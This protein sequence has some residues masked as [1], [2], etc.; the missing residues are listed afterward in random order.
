L[1]GSLGRFRR[2][3]SLPSGVTLPQAVPTFTCLGAAG[4]VAVVWSTVSA[5]QYR[6]ELLG[7]GWAAP[8]PPA[9]FTKAHAPRTIVVASVHGDLVAVYKPAR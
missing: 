1:P 3:G 2:G 4:R 7:T 5:A 6:Q 8:G 9:V